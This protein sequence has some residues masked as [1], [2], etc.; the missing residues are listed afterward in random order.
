MEAEVRRMHCNF[1][2]QVMGLYLALCELCQLKEKTPKRGLVVRPIF[3]NYTKS[4]C[5]VDLIDVR[6]EPV[7]C[8]RF[9]MKY[10]ENF[11]KVTILRPLKSK[12]ASEVAYQLMDIFCAF[13]APISLHSDNGREYA[14]KKYK[15]WLICGPE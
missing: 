11:T 9:L 3:P 8:Y 2:Q 15:T 14:K 4:R 10:Q 1:T 12:T 6:S 5:Q 13:G 7:G